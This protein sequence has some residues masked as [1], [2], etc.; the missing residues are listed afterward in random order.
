MTSP[1]AH[2]HREQRPDL[3]LPAVPGQ[4]PEQALE[5]G[6]VERLVPVHEE[7][8]RVRAEGHGAVGQQRLGPA[9]HAQVRLLALAVEV[10]VEHGVRVRPRAGPR[11]RAAAERS[12]SSLARSS[13]RA[14]RPSPV[15]CRRASAALAGR[16]A[17]PAGSSSSW[18]MPCWSAR[19]LGEGRA[20]P[21]LLAGERA[22]HGERQGEVAE[23]GGERRLQI[24]GAGRGAAAAGAATSAIARSV[25]CAATPS[26]TGRPSAIGATPPAASSAAT[27]G[28]PAAR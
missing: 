4:L 11:R 13:C 26:A 1:G 24:E 28:S 27:P 17:A 21:A 20:E 15:T 5:V 7:G 19:E 23:G 12:S 10:E 18:S 9:R 22:V 6:R 14:R 25:A 3:H 8:E 16:G 2:R